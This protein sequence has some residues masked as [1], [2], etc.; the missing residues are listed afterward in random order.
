MNV[1]YFKDQFKIKLPFAKDGIFWNGQP[2]EF[3]NIGYNLNYSQKF[4]VTPFSTNTGAY[5][6]ML[7]HNGHDFAGNPGTPIVA[8]CKLWVTFISIDAGG[9]G[10]HI[11]AETETKTINGDNIKMEFVL[12]HMREKPVCK[13]M[14]WL[15]EGDPIGFMGSTGFSTGPHTHLG[16]RPLI[17]NKDGSVAWALG[18]NG[19]RGYTDLT[20]FF[21]TKPIY[22][23]QILINKPMTKYD[24]KL[25]RNKDT[26]AM[27]WVYAGYAREI[28]T[29]DDSVMTIATYLLRN[30][31]GVNVSDS[32]W[33]KLIFKSIRD[34]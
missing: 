24:N 20:D 6:P 1:D 25:V 2:D 22:D 34:D 7:G 8:P 23:K 31:G 28:K 21:R 27:A 26:G 10:W 33:N 4:G 12:A 11:F 32:E 16:G 19:Y 3:S 9:Y 15:N 30:E 17:V 14:S 29:S 5:K 18:D 13:L